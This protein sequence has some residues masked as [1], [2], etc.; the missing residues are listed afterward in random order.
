MRRAASFAL[1][2]VEGSATVAAYARDDLL[3]KRRPVMQRWADRF[4]EQSRREAPAT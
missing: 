2:H 4:M 3:E 1:A